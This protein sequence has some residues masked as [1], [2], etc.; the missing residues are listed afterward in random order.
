MS[1]SPIPTHIG[2]KEL[3]QQRTIPLTFDDEPLTEVYRI[4][5]EK[6]IINVHE[7]NGF[8]IVDYK[9]FFVIIDPLS[10]EHTK[11]EAQYI[12]SKNGKIIVKREDKY[13]IL[14]VI[15]KEFTRIEENIKV[16]RQLV[17]NPQGELILYD[18]DADNNLYIIT[19]IGKIHVNFREEERYSFKHI[20]IYAS[21]DIIFLYNSK[22]QDLH[23]FDYAG[24]LFYE[25]DSF[26]FDEIICTDNHMYTTTTC[27]EGS[28]NLE[29]ITR[30]DSKLSYKTLFT[31]VN[32]IL[33]ISRQDLILLDVLGD[34]YLIKGHSFKLMNPDVK[35][36]DSYG[37]SVAELKDGYLIVYK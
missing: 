10:S 24:N 16:V 14:D 22:Y 26:C 32:R 20:Q 19:P 9:K 5:I 30:K 29:E 3:I 7:T 35:S 34:T 1:R 36:I 25:D 2:W 12:M 13:Y 11:I 15:S 4:K 31:N 27:D 18:I 8:W 23:A 21:N 28:G 33:G 17:L 6:G 37:S